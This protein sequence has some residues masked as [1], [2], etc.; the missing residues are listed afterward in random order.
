[1]SYDLRFAVKVDIGNECRFV[2]IG[3]PEYDHP[4]YNLSK[5]FRTCMNWDYEQGEYYKLSDIEKNIL[6]GIKELENSPNKYRKY[7]PENKWGTVEGALKVLKG[8]Y[9]DM[10]EFSEEQN[11]PLEYLYLRW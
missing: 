4:T 3:Y 2:N 6:R 8:L 5:M 11:I 10:H 7:E 9:R 1:M